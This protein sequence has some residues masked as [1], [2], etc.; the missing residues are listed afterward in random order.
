[1]ISQSQAT[2]LSDSISMIRIALA[3]LAALGCIV[4]AAD[5]GWLPQFAERL[6]DLPHGDK[7]LHFLLFGGLALVAN[8]A[9]A[10]HRPN[11][12]ARA[13]V[14]GSMLV[15]IV[16]TAEEY[17]NQYLALRDWSLGDLT[18]NYLGIVCL[19]MLPLWRP[20][21]FCRITQEITDD[22]LPP[23]GAIAR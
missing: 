22:S 1:L 18:A 19:G 15:I 14:T 8:L 2:F 20:Q 4:V 10:K 6:H 21:L 13:I 3:Y 17:S 9:L 7:V 5:A 12:F 11:S 23:P 16:A